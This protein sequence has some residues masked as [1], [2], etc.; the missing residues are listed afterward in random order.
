MYR[1]LLVSLSSKIK[2]RI[3]NW[4][5]SSRMF[6]TCSC[7]WVPPPTVI[8][9][10]TLMFST[11]RWSCTPHVPPCEMNCEVLIQTEVQ[12]KQN[13]HPQIMCHKMMV[14][15]EIC[16]IQQPNETSGLLEILQAHLEQLAPRWCCIFP[17]AKS[18]NASVDFFPPVYSIPS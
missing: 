11:H 14:W 4:M 8:H 7:G 10:L 13:H 12:Y 5:W 9:L 3:F 6:H 18:I 16:V 2:N 17:F 15:N 1:I